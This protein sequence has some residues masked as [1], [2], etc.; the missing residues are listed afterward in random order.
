MGGRSVQFNSTER[1]LLSQNVDPLHSLLPLRVAIVRGLTPLPL[2]ADRR[3]VEVR[4]RLELGH[5]SRPKPLVEMRRELFKEVSDGQGRIALDGL[6]QGG[7]FECD[8]NFR[9][10]QHAFDD[11]RMLLCGRERIADAAR[12][13]AGSVWV[14]RDVVMDAVTRAHR[15][16]GVKIDL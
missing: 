6:C 8:V 9:M 13:D 11:Q 16:Q 4:V 1:A 12:D 7:V 3:R 10:W 2:A 5:L 14:F 15:H